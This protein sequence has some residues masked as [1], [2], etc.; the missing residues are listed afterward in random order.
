MTY[1]E[2]HELK[3]I[4]LQGT[5]KQLDSRSP[6]KEIYE[7]IFE[8]VKPEYWKKYVEHQGKIIALGVWWVQLINRNLRSLFQVMYY[9]YCLGEMRS[10]LKEKGISTEFL[11]TWKFIAGDKTAKSVQLVKYAEVIYFGLKHLIIESI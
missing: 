6:G 2:K 5:Q 10:I 11:N 9:I 3:L 8:D 4:Q 7:L 1:L